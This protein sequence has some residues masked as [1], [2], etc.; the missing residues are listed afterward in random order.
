MTTLTL[1]LTDELA[2]L[3]EQAAGEQAVNDYAVV[4]LEQAARADLGADS[5]VAGVTPGL[6]P[7]DHTYLLEID[8]SG[9]L[10][11]TEQVRAYL[12]SRF[13]QLDEEIS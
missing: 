3:V 6:T 7:D 1:E 8:Q 4:V 2:A 12:Q 11:S 5:T 9:P 10:Y 13:P